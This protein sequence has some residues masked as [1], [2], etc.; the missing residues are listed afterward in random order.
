MPAE[1]DH[2]ASLAVGDTGWGPERPYETIAKTADLTAQG[3]ALHI[4][5]HEKQW[6]LQ[7]PP[8]EKL[9]P[10]GRDSRSLSLEHYQLPLEMSLVRKGTI[11]RPQRSINRTESIDA[12][13]LICVL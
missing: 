2:K 4:R 9:Q 1:W 3:P 6:P 5:G 10:R 8:A 7:D 13:I 12:P 11:F